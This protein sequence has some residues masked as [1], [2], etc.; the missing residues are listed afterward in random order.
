MYKNLPIIVGV[1]AI[2][3]GDGHEDKSPPKHSEMYKTRRGEEKEKI[4]YS[5][6]KK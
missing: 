2:D 4:A 6:V 5:C 1:H 3:V